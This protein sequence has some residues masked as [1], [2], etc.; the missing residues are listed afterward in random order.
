MCV[1]WV[2]IDMSSEGEGK[3]IGD[4]GKKLE[5]EGGKNKYCIS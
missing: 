3:G 1:G 5:R 2:V 4:E